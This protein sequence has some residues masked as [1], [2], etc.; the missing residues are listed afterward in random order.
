MGNCLDDFVSQAYRVTLTD[1]NHHL[2]KKVVVSGFSR[3]CAEIDAVDM[4]ANG[5][6]YCIKEIKQLP[7]IAKH[8]IAFP[9]FVDWLFK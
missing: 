1:C 8:F 5:T 7:K 2:E 9:R 6:F 3:R 4:N